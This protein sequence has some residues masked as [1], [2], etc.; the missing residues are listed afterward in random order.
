MD[1]KPRRSRVRPAEV[2]VTP[3]PLKFTIPLRSNARLIPPFQS[4][5]SV[6]NVQPAPSAQP[7]QPVQPGPSTVHNYFT[8]D[9]HTFN[10]LYNPAPQSYR[11]FIF[12]TV[13]LN[14][15]FK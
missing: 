5:H 2:N 12:Y 11:E 4:V 13:K 1:G 10:G 15:L 3:V 14:I 9:G 8:G 7:V 6:E